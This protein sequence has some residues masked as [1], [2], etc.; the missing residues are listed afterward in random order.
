MAGFA[1][2][3]QIRIAGNA[4]LIVSHSDNLMYNTTKYEGYFTSQKSMASHLLACKQCNSNSSPI[5]IHKTMHN[6]FYISMANL[7]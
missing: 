5:K 7:V 4:N 6:S 2:H 3:V 1:E